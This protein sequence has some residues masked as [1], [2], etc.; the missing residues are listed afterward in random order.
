MAAWPS[1]SVN[2]EEFLDRCAATPHASDGARSFAEVGASADPTH[3]A[4]LF[5]AFACALEIP[6]ALVTFERHFVRSVV[7]KMARSDAGPH[8]A[9][10]VAQRLR[11]KLFVGTAESPA[12]I[13]A[14]GGRGPL[15]GWIRVV[16]T[17][18]GRDLLRASRRGEGRAERDI[19]PRA[20][21]G[22]PELAFL[23]QRYARELSDAFA[24]TMV[25]LSAKEKSMLNL[26]YI[27]GMSS[28]AIGRL[29]GVSGAAVRLWLKECRQAVLTETRRALSE[30]AGLDAGDLDS[31]LRAIGSHI[32]VSIR[33]ILAA[34]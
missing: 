29:Y 34:P 31:V 19:H 27:D 3:A 21:G 4:D 12:R 25:S 23:R 33:R 16:A 9:D 13:K 1:V 8:F 6:G 10:D 15:A 30:R 28:A 22:D 24:R 20:A 2:V 7:A 32:D 26:Y 5:L 17:R 14:Y 18:V 11:E